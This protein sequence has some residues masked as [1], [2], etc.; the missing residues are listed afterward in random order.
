MSEAG[1][2]LRSGA[3]G[4]D[5]PGSN[6]QHKTAQLLSRVHRP[7]RLHPQ[8]LPAPASQLV[9]ERPPQLSLRPASPSGFPISEVASPSCRASRAPN[10]QVLCHT[11]CSLICC[12]QSV[13]T[14]CCSLEMPLKCTPLLLSP[15][16]L[17]PSLGTLLVCPGSSA[18]P[19][20]DASTQDL[21][22]SRSS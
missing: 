22:L 21:G 4:G 6:F 1:G 8:M 3:P 7:P 17:N 18:P 16:A 11:S 2:K 12:S 19:K 9:W 20:P 10:L 15:P 5:R 14:F 13:R